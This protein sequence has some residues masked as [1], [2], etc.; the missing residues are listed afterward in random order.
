MRSTP[1]IVA[2]R[3]DEA[4]MELAECNVALPAA[5]LDAP[6]MA[7]FVKAVDDVNWLADTS[8]GFLWRLPPQDGPVTFGQL[9]DERVI[10]TLSIW[11]DFE[12]LQKYVY[13]TG[14]ALFMQRRN[15]W[16]VPLGGFTT[17]MWWVDEG[18]RPTMDEGL[19][20][21]IHL[22]LHGPSPHAFSLRRQFDPEGVADRR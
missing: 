18:E 7:G 8:K 16:F 9:G 10:V 4:P 14:H 17:A 22:R 1:K 15:R 13:R 5:P 21:L 6:A 19:G 12:A 11:T 3:E 20:R 2:R